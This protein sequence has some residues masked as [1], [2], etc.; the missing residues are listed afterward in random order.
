MANCYR[1]LCEAIE[2]ERTRLP[3]GQGSVARCAAMEFT[4]PNP[5]AVARPAI[6]GIIGAG[7]IARMVA[8]DLARHPA[9]RVGAVSSRDAA[10]A[11]NLAGSLGG[12]AVERDYRQLLQRPEIQAV[13][14]ATPPALHREMILAALAAG[15]HVV[16]EKPLVADAAELPE[17]MAAAQQRPDLKV[18]SCSS[19]FLVC[20]PVRKAS[21]WLA[22]GQLGKILR[23]RL[24]NAMPPIA[25]S[26]L[27][28]WK[29]SRATAGG[30]LVMDWG[31]Y[32][33][34]WLQL[35]L[36]PE[37]DPVRIFARTSD[38]GHEEAS[39]ETGFAA[40]LLCRSGLA[41]GWE[42]R[43]ESGPPFQRAEVRGTLGGLDLPFMPGSSLEGLTHYRLGSEQS[44]GREI[45]S[46]PV[47]SW[48]SILAYPILDLAEAIVHG[49]AVASPLAA[50][51]K[52]HRVIEALYRSA[53]SGRSEAV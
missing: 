17:I 20:P 39:L 43:T 42:R 44:L 6:F 40:E 12:A 14:I 5:A 34:D 2:S 25:L 28:T 38:W 47:G 9:I 18:A 41:I 15:K 24:Q 36:G 53:A 48:G 4:S 32:D 8:P 50:Q 37:F 13:Y 45:V 51:V 30:G 23:V 19:R 29:R 52:I 26:S 3:S 11:Q 1:F 31:P 27:P 10:A 35:L 49:R 7:E 16:C 46:D 33:L 22:A 21:E